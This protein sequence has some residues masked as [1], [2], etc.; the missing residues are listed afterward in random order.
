MN[1]LLVDKRLSLLL[2]VLWS[3]LDKTDY[4]MRWVD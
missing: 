3:I 1:Y 2:F 4:Q